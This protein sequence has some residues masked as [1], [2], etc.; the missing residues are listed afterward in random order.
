MAGNNARGGYSSASYRELVPT[1]TM[2]AI[3]VDD[4]VLADSEAIAE[5]LEET[6]AEPAMLPQ[7]PAARARC[8]ARPLPR[9]LALSRHPARTRGAQAVP[10]C[11][12]GHS[13]QRYCQRA[14]AGAESTFRRTVA[15]ARLGQHARYA[16]FQSR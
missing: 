6:I 13:R 9:T 15:I 4:L 14:I 12:Q 8:R 2:P 5:Y 7:D 3:E 10:A 1:G 16:I 11:R